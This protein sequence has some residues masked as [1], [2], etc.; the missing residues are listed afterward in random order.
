M[1]TIQLAEA[2]SVL[3]QVL[4]PSA[5]S[6]AL[7]PLM[8]KGTV[9]NVSVLVP[10]FVSVIGAVLLLATLWEPKETGLGFAVTA[11]AV[12]VPVKATCWGLPGEVSVKDREALSAP[13]WTG[14]N[15]TLT[16]H[17]APGASV[18]PVHESSLIWKFDAPVPASTTLL[19][20]TPAAP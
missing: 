8:L 6:P 9:P 1:F 5:K 17:E 20:V 19:T 18:I 2:T 7:E 15:T 4:D 12:P 10:L 11:G 13:V 16:E 3:L 14:A